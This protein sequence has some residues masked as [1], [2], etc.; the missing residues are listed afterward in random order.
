LV[1]LKI[2]DEQIVALSDPR[3]VESKIIVRENA[4]AFM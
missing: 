4:L 1:Q 3:E 2:S